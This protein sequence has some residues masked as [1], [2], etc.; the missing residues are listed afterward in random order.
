MGRI[1]NAD[2]RGYLETPFRLFHLED[3]QGGDIPYH[4]HEF[5]KLILFLTGDVRYLIEGRNYLLKEGD[6]LLIPAYA[7]H[8][9]MI[10]R[11][12]TYSRYILWIR[13]ES[14]ERWDLTSGFSWQLEISRFSSFASPSQPSLIVC[15]FAY[16]QAS[17]LG[18]GKTNSA[19]NLSFCVP[20]SFKRS[21][22]VQE[23]LPVVHR[24]RLSAS[25]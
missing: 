25:A 12:E 21:L 19:L 1:E 11:E 2:K 17:L 3:T 10:S 6:I 20:T 15:G 9:P 24:L 7:I 18:R 4:Y 13:P 8:Q 5:H 14:L 22:V 23:S 16:T